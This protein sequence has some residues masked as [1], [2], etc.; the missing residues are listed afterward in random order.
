MF[1]KINKEIDYKED[2][3]GI[4]DYKEV[5]QGIPNHKEISLG[6]KLIV[7]ILRNFYYHTNAVYIIV[8]G[9]G[10]LVCQDVVHSFSNPEAWTPA[11]DLVNT[12]H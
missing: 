10:G 7:Y 2:V 4:P 11:N 3:Q 9:E 5:A 6:Y 1:D 8:E 12:K